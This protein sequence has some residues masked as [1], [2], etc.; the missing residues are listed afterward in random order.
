LFFDIEDDPTQEFVYLHGVYERSSK[1]ER[2]LDFTAKSLT[3]DAERSAW[4]KFWEYINSLPQD[5]FAVYYYSPHEKTTYKKI[6]KTLSDVIS[7]DEV[8][9][10]FV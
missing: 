5:D 6:A 9:D 2:F 10:F 7:E 8:N 3:L 4:T 1:G